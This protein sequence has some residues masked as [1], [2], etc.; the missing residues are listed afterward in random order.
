MVKIPPYARIIIILLGLSIVTVLLYVGQNILIP[1]LLS[2]LFAIL[3][4]PIVLFLSDKLRFPDVLAVLVS[5]ALF[6]IFVL[7]IVFFISWQVSDIADDWNKIKANLNEHFHNFQNWVKQRFHISYN[8]QESY[9]N[10]VTEQTLTGNREFMGNTFNTFTGT[11]LNAVL[12]PVYTFLI[13][14][15]RDLLSKFLYKLAGY[16]HR[17]IV[18]DVLANIK[19]VVQSFIVGLLI[20]AGII[21]VLISGGLMLLGVEYAL[22]LGVITALLNL[23]PY[24]GILIAG[25]ITI[26]ATLV[27]STS[28]SLILAVIILNSVVQLI[29]NNIIVPKIVGNKVRINALAS[30]VGVIVGG[31]I[32]GVAGMFLAIPIIAILKVI[33]DRVESLEAWGILMGDDQPQSQTKQKFKFFFFRNRSGNGK[34]KETVTKGDQAIAHK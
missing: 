31:A 19:T 8:K 33:F 25:T 9:I 21:T 12:I 16:K 18:T 27:N 30:I 29:D 4:R 14:L 17:L 1:L 28:I 22:L 23:I 2:F 6:V 10:R 15:Y 26:M 5:V 32:A 13:L 24:I 3:L 7:A 34:S 11:L 20:E